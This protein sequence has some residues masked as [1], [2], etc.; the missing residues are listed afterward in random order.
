MTL[1]NVTCL[2]PSRLEMLLEEVSAGLAVD[3]Y[4]LYGRV[5]FHKALQVI[6][7]LRFERAKVIA[8]DDDRNE[9][10]NL[11]RSSDPVRWQPLRTSHTTYPA[12]V[13]R[14]TRSVYGVAL[15]TKPRANP[16]IVQNAF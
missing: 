2:E 5:L 12:A 9:L 16:T 15:Q 1:I 6:G 10:I 4:L 3:D 11:Y 8:L 14:P 7:G 13:M